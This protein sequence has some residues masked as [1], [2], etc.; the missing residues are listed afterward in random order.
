MTIDYNRE[1]VIVNLALLYAL[2]GN[3]GLRRLRTNGEQSSRNTTKHGKRD[4]AHAATGLRSSEGNLPLLCL[5]LT[6]TCFPANHKS[7]TLL[8][9]TVTQCRSADAITTPYNLARVS[10]ENFAALQYNSSP[11]VNRL[12]PMQTQLHVG[13]SHK[14]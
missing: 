13:D 1:I 12:H 10:V 6:M 8:L 5:V 7:D 9:G 3:H 4:F 11:Q 2:D 14:P